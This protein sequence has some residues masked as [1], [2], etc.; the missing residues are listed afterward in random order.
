MEALTLVSISFVS[1]DASRR[2]KLSSGIFIADHDY[3]PLLSLNKKSQPTMKTSPRPMR[4]AHPGLL[5]SQ[6]ESVI[7]ANPSTTQFMP[8]LTQYMPCAAQSMVVTYLWPYNGSHLADSS[9]CG[10]PAIVRSAPP[11][12]L[13]VCVNLSTAQQSEPSDSRRHAGGLSRPSVAVP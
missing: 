12:W 11:A 9:P 13:G 6:R 7:V 5:F 1:C 4:A 2:R 8:F 10:S 3:R